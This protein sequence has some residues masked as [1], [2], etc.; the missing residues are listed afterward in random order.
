MSFE[1]GIKRKVNSQYWASLESLPILSATS[2]YNYQKGDIEQA[3]FL[4]ECLKNNLDYLWN[5]GI[6][7]VFLAK[8]YYNPKIEEKLKSK[9]QSF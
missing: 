9:G 1:E 3:I 5:G 2:K 7:I 8:K 6:N 4:Y